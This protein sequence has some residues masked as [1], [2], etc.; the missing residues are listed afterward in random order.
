MKKLLLGAILTGLFLVVVG[1]GGG[2][3]SND[4]TDRLASSATISSS[5]SG[6]QPAGVGY[7]CMSS[8]NDK[9]TMQITSVEFAT[10]TRIITVHCSWT[11]TN[12]SGAAQIVKLSDENTTT[13][14]M[15]DNSGKKY[16]HSAG[17]GA[18]YTDTQLSS[19]AVTG[20]YTFTALNGGVTSIHIYDSTY[21]VKTGTIYIN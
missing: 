12:A 10:S 17:T 13:L 15:V 3:S 20:T 18:A 19:T 8:S 16:D 5:T 2:G 1:C 4:T 9:I 6:A 11:A 14:Y 21:S 7:I